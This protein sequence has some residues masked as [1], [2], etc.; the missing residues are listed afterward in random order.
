MSVVHDRL[1]KSA[2]QGHTWHVRLAD[3]T[4]YGPMD[5]STLC[6]WAAQNRIAPGSDVS[7]DQRQWQAAETIPQLK[8]EMQPVLDQGFT[9]SGIPAEPPATPPA[10]A[11]EAPAA[12]VAE[13]APPPAAFEQDVPTLAVR[14]RAT[15]NG[16]WKRN[17]AMW[18]RRAWTAL[19]ASRN[20][21]RNSIA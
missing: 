6:E 12:L 10:S 4:V 18:R 21:R 14:L 13:I 5:L 1:K 19:R 15:P 7:R 8:M 20:C 3:H 11:P 2:E 17:S 9:G 16:N